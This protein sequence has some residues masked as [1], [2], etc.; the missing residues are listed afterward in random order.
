MNSKHIFVSVASLALMTC[1]AKTLLHEEKCEVPVIVYQPQMTAPIRV[2]EPPKEE[3]AP[4]PQNEAEISL[5]VFQEKKP[6]IAFQ[7]V[8]E[9]SS[10]QGSPEWISKKQPLELKGDI[11]PELIPASSK[12]WEGQHVKLYK[13][14]GSFCEAS[15]TKLSLFGQLYSYEEQIP[16]TEQAWGSVTAMGGLRLVGELDITSC[17]GAVFARLASLPTPFIATPKEASKEVTKLALSQLKRLSLYKKAQKEYLEYQK[18]DPKEY[19]AKS[20]ENFES[21][22]E[23]KIVTKGQETFVLVNAQAGIGCGGFWGGVFV[24]FRLEGENL[25]L[26][27][28]N[29][30]SITPDLV[31][32]VNNDQNFDWLEDQDLL[33][34]RNGTFEQTQS[35]VI[36]SDDDSCGC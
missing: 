28:Q 5:L 10:L 19:K 20:W 24:I 21:K 22:P 8:Y 3:L 31:L 29:D 27:Y 30:E 14:D 32:D 11:N 34:W 36:P 18:E 25:T 2:A 13:A 9:R 16:E 7:N 23:V 17:E 35:V 4:V 1:H 15:V 26:L 6:M 33:Q 12:A